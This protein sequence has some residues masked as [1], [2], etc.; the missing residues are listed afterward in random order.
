MKFMGKFISGERN[1]TA[2]FEEYLAALGS[3]GPF[4]RRPL[5]GLPLRYGE[6]VVRVNKLKNLM[7]TICERGGLKGNYTNHSGKR[8]CANQL[9][10][11]G[12]DEQEIMN[13]TRHR[14]EKSVHQYKRSATNIQRKVAALLGPPQ[15]SATSSKRSFDNSMETEYKD[16]IEIKKIK[17]EES[18]STSTDITS[19]SNSSIDDMSKKKPL[20]SNCNIH[21]I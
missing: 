14:F 15:A 17:H 20:F 19:T 4:N 2:F 9:Y 7:K 12:I 3:R 6:Q 13:R 16:E 18:L 5:N 8:T 11:A 1:I 10:M 21:L